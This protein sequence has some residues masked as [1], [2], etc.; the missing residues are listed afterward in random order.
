[1][2]QRELEELVE[3]AV[4]EL[5]EP[6]KTVIVL[7]YRDRMLLKEIGSVL[8]LTESRISQ[9]HSSAIYRLNRKVRSSIQ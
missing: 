4:D 3:R 7:Y 1:M 8:G 6:E 9:I 2:E 5:P